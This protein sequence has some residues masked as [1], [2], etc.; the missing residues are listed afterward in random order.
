MN[1]LVLFI[2]LILIICIFIPNNISYMK[3]R[4]VY[5]DAYDLGNR[6]LKVASENNFF[7]LEKPAVMFDID[8]TLLDYSGK[9]IKYIIDL[10]NKC[11]QI[12]LIVIIIT[13]RLDQHRQY[14]IDELKSN[15][16][17]Y[18]ALFLRSQTD[19]FNTFK[20]KIKKQLSEN[21]NITTIMSIGDNIIDIDGAYSGYW[22]KLPNQS[23]KKLYHLNSSGIPEEII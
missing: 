18:S 23:D 21:N 13:A 3:K 2:I 1:N 22:I 10:L 19:D 6:Y 17:E 11:N 9:K 5:K 12:G 14:T 16:I 8:D 20:S 4:N 15:G 7:D